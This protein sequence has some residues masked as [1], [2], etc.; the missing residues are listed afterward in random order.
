MKLLNMLIEEYGNDLIRCYETLRPL[1]VVLRPLPA[2]PSMENIVKLVTFFPNNT[3]IDPHALHAKFPNFVAHIDLLN[4][5]FENMEQ[6]AEFSEE[7]KSIFPLTNRC[8]Q[9]LLTIPATAAK[10]ECTFS[11]LK[12]AKTPLRTTMVDKR[13]ESLLLLSCEKDI[14]DS[15][16]IDVISKDWANIKM[17]R[18]KFI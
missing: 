15:I 6:I 16:D 5:T 8:Y 3:D 14:A 7:R 13:L 4:N 2:K 18:I 12:I 9:L 10:D 1:I 11:R 17:R